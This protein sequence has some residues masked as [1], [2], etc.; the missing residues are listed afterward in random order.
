MAA[1]PPQEPV[2][3]APR[4]TGP[5]PVECAQDRFKLNPRADGTAH[6][7]TE[8]N[9]MSPDM[10]YASHLDADTGAHLVCEWDVTRLF[11]LSDIA[12]SGL[13]GGWAQPEEEHTWNDGFDATLLLAVDEGR[14]AAT[15]TIE[16]QPYITGQRPVQDITIYING[17]RAAFRRM[18]ART[19]HTLT[20]RIEPEWWVT[21]DDRPALNVLF[22]LPGS[23]RPS[24]IGDGSDGRNVGFCF[25]TLLLSRAE[26]S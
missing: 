23:V 7:P 13:K 19:G 11:G 6:L 9:S 14:G 24:E 3:R 15:L 26:P 1:R 5:R 16:G 8:S 25:R 2:A 4:T 22:H 21:R 10:N 12:T 20:I 18:T 17:Y